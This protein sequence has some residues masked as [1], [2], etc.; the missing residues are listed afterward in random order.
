[1]AIGPAAANVD[2]ALVTAAHERCLHVHPYTVDDPAEMDRLLDA[3]VDGMFTNTPAVLIERRGRRPAPPD[4]CPGR[5]AS[6]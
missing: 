4:H 1:V 2:T 3:G 5:S 6:D